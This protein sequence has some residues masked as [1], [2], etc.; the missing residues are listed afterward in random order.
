MGAH[1]LSRWV[2]SIRQAAQDSQAS[3]QNWNLDLS[4]SSTLSMSETQLFPNKSPRRY[5]DD[6]D[7]PETTTIVL[8]R[9][10]E[11]CD[12]PIVVCPRTDDG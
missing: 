11:I 1:Q 8:H 10:R 12:N 2:K 5:G 6:H 3:Q 7:M 9:D 4:Q